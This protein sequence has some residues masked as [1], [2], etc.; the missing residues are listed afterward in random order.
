MGTV[1]FY[2]SHT[3]AVATADSSPIDVVGYTEYL[4]LVGESKLGIG[5]HGPYNTI[6]D[7]YAAWPNAKSTGAAP[8]PGAAAVAGAPSN[9]AS[10]LT[11]GVTGA[12]GAFEG[13]AQALTD[14]SLWRSLGW[15]A[16]GIILLIVGIMLWLKENNILPEVVPVPI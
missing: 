1:Y 4:Y 9:E 11:G 13:I 10:Q 16:M 3:N 8:I 7:L 5:V 15:L 12:L 14:G 6:A 2:E